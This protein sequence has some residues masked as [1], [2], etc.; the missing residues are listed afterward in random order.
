ME[1]SEIL[2]PPKTIAVVG[3]SD[4]PER[5][6]HE[7][8]SYLI[9]HGFTII[10]VNPMITEFQG[11]K[12]FPSLAEIPAD[13]Q[14]DVV[15]IFRRS[16]EVP[17]IVQWVVESKLR[18]IIWMQEGVISPQAKQLAEDNGM[19]VVMDQC[20]MKLHRGMNAG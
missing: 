4:K 12:S 11:I 7:V 14:I 13:V 8:A 2:T 5:P 1:I 6:S 16:E 3:L 17:A 18:P 19:Q 15:D 9:E 20:M 10:P